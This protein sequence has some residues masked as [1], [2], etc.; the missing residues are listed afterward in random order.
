MA[1]ATVWQDLPSLDRDVARGA[2]A[3]ARWREGLSRD[4]EGH[5]E[6]EPLEVVRRVTGKTAWDALGALDTSAADVPLRDALRSWVYALLQARVGRPEEVVWARAAAAARGRLEGSAPRLVSWREAWR[7][8]VA[9][10]TRA[11]TQLWLDA[12]VG[13]ARG[14]GEVAR[15]RAARRAEVA[16]RL[17]LAHPWAPLV[18]ADPAALRAAAR[19]LLDATEELSSAVWKEALG[20]DTGPAAVL[21]AA[22]ARDAPEGWPPR[23]TGRWLE[24][25][26][27]PG[28]RGLRIDL[29]SLPAVRG[30][31]SFSRALYAFGFAVRGGTEP[32]GGGPVPY[33]T[34]RAPA[35]VA[36]HRVA[37]AFAAL[38]A[39]A[40]WQSRALGLGRTRAL[41]Q[42][43]VLARAALLD[44]R[45]HAA[46]LLLDDEAA[47][48]ARELFDEIGARLFGAPLDRRLRG[49]WPPARDDEPAR[50]LAL[51]QSRAF[52]AALRDRFDVDWYRNPGAWAH[53]RSLAAGPAREA[54]AE[55]A[56][57][58]TLDALAV[59]LARAFE[60]ALG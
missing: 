60:D 34:A 54:G 23:A 45:L 27:A 46:R 50:F 44:A 32:S 19:R 42:A 1:E 40:S 21:H 41:A 48:A 58:S 52:V 30:A 29:P 8:V 18:E 17:G 55:R 56:D 25:V 31:S 9:A 47:F 59:A 51:L 37:F 43:R 33:A 13:A 5:A 2:A 49:A 26:F 22:V 15:A 36:A 12:A 10:R 28:A 3:L 20:V 39:D 14:L 16:R 57:P 53:L 7:G 35:F 38:P 6:D 24:D 11:E 4:P